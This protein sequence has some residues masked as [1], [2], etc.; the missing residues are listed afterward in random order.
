MAGSAERIDTSTRDIQLWE[1][2]LHEV[3]DSQAVHFLSEV[4]HLNRF[5]NTDGSHNSAAIAGVRQNLIP[6]TKE[7]AMP[8]A[9][10]T[11]YQEY[12]DGTYWW[13]DQTPEQVAASGYR[14]HEHP[15]ALARVD[16]E[17]EEAQD[18]NDLKPGIIK[19]FLSP[20]MS[21]KDATYEVAKHEHLAD[22]DMIRIHMV[23]MGEYGQ[24]R[25]KF[26]QSVLARRIPLSAWVAMLRDP[27]NIFGKAIEIEDEE[28][29]LSV[30]KIYRQLELPEAALPKGVV[31]IIEAVLPYA[32]TAAQV[33]IREELMLFETDQQELHRKAESI[34][35]RWLHF[36]QELADS[37]F[38]GFATESIQRFIRGLALEWNDEMAREVMGNT[39]ADGSI[40]MTRS[41]AAKLEA[42]KRNTLWVSG[43]VI[44]GNQRILKQ[45]APD[46][47]QQIYVNEM[48]MQT[49]L[50]AGG[51]VQ[52]L[53]QADVESSRVVAQQN[54]TAGGGCPGSGNG[55]FGSLTQK[56]EAGQGSHE[57]KCK[58]VK[59]GQSVK[60]PGCKKQ[61]HA[62]VPNRETIYCS[63]PKC[64]LAAPHLKGNTIKV[65]AA[66]PAP[67]QAAEATDDY[68]AA[69]EKG[70]EGV[71][72]KQRAQVQ[73]I[74]GLAL[75]AI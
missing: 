28:S 6:A 56:S 21:P 15:A 34:A 23:D 5:R 11:T 49:A 19:V 26:M 45:L 72:T 10:S 51:T 38:A 7:A 70:E 27:H 52:E 68:E 66:K 63:N 54:V 44:T 29:A 57:K 13:L 16:I 74:G 43:G 61:V 1:E 60:C 3:V 30:M 53:E 55:F 59:D 24:P 62:I 20:R 12:R 75:S 22:D 32:D 46:I 65:E 33:K 67:A 4:D 50:R 41:L 9:I 48:F 18:T 17:V 39:R 36:E 14:F 8:Y 35:E 69:T 31:S 2:E 58:E 40:K 64:N 25:G 71:K 37:V 42:S 73:P 47:V